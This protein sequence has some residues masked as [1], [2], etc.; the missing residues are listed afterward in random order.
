VLCN[1]FGYVGEEPNRE[2]LDRLVWKSKGKFNRTAPCSGQGGI[3]V[4]SPF[5]LA[6][7]TGHFDL[8]AHLPRS[9]YDCRVCSTLRFV[10][11]PMTDNLRPR[12]PPDLRI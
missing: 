3:G 4:A 1:R 5:I 6:I 8:V 7:S 12:L 9:P 10:L 2:F 11:H